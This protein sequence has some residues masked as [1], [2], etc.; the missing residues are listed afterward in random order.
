[1]TTNLMSFAHSYGNRAVLQKHL[2]DVVS[3]GQM[4][5]VLGAGVSKPLGL[6]DWDELIDRMYRAASAPIPVALNNA[7]KAEHF[8][9]QH[10]ATL[11]AYLA[12]VRTA[13]YQGITISLWE[14]RANRTLAAVSAIARSAHRDNSTPVITFNF[15][16]LL[17]DLAAALA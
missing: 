6:P 7:R 17:R 12:A 3:E 1:M 10:C 2:A 14:L 16:D 5:L 8:R 9:S 4:A 15:D 13:L 11:D